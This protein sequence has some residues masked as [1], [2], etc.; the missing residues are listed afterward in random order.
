MI[1][2]KNVCAE[3]DDLVF[4]ANDG[5]E[6]LGTLNGRFEDGVLVINSVRSERFLIDGLCRAAMNYAFNR[7]VNRC[8]FEI[9]DPEV[10]K[11]LIGLGF[12]KIDDNFIPD[13]DNFFNSHKTCGK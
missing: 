11:E 1:T 2:I 13:I 8:R 7:S 10:T 5:E 9:D 12:V 4:K 6:V 3:S